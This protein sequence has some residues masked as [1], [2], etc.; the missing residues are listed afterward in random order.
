MGLLAPRPTPNLEDQVLLFIWHLPCN[1]PG[2]VKLSSD[3]YSSRGPW[4]TQ[5]PH[6]P[7]PTPTFTTAVAAHGAGNLQYRPRLWGWRFFYYISSIEEK[8][9]IQVES[10]PTLFDWHASKEWNARITL[11]FKNLWLSVNCCHWIQNYGFISVSNVFLP[12]TYTKRKKNW[13]GW[14][15]KAFSLLTR[16]KRKKA[17]REKT[18]DQ[19]QIAL[20]KAETVAACSEKQV[21]KENFQMT[22]KIIWE[23]STKPTFIRL[24]VVLW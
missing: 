19:I 4:G 21:N 5:A 14:V 12:L 7:S 18:T 22:K 23:I 6:P 13:V 10:W 16:T 2:L 8:E 24:L 17:R 15:G 9:K 1:L 11:A 20:V 3:R